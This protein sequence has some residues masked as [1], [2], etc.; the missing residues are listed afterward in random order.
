MGKDLVLLTLGSARQ[1]REFCRVAERLEYEVE[2]QHVR[3]EVQDWEV[4]DTDE[5]LADGVEALGQLS[6]QPD[7]VIN[8]GRASIPDGIR[9]IAVIMELL[10][11]DGRL[12]DGTKLIG[13]SARA[14]QVWG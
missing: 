13:P 9:R 4:R 7:A 10:R 5:I 8:F 11:A 1:S 2:H 3:E 6:R 14:A 12:A